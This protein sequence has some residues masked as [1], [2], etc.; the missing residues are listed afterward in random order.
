M[1]RVRE[2]RDE[3][4]RR[5]ESHGDAEADDDAAADEL[6]DGVAETLDQ[7][8]ENHDAAPREDGPFSPE[9]VRDEGGK[10][11]GNDCAEGVRGA[12]EAEE[13]ALGTSEF[14]VPGGDALEA[15]QDRAIVA[16]CCADDEA[17]WSEDAI[18]A[19]EGW[20]E[21]GDCGAVV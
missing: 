14:A 19:D 10:R 6:P 17:G 9:A 2:L 15:C 21:G 16:V 18:E 1:P 13:G 7:H 20:C 8:A 3:H 12:G 11:G 4:R 5:G